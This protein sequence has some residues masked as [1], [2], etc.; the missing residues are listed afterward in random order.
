[1]ERVRWLI[2]PIGLLATAIALYAFSRSSWSWEGFTPAS[3]K[4]YP[5][6]CFCEADRGGPVR[7]PSN[8]W[9]N[10]GFVAVGLMVIA[11]KKKGATRWDMH[12]LQGTLIVLLGLTSI[13]FHGSLTYL[14]EWCDMFSMLLWASFI[15]LR[16]LAMRYDLS[17]RT[18]FLLHLLL[19]AILGSVTWDHVRISAGIFVGL[20]V[21]M[22]VTDVL[23][24]QRARLNRPWL[25][26]AL[27]VQATAFGIW[28]LD[29][30]E[31]INNPRSLFQGHAVW[32]I[33]SALAAGCLYLRYLGVSV[34]PRGEVVQG[35]AAVPA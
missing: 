14:G 3:C 35:A 1:M 16:S 4:Q 30:F 6:T 17:R 11:A 9:S 32:H 31:V 28:L 24:G 22:I 8:T 12:T 10:L 33:L 25:A 21:C 15:A 18:M 5:H 20:L 34:V 13:Y 27:G 23:L 29:K 7:Q 2:V 26:A 19:N